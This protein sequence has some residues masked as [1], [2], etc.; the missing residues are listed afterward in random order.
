MYLQTNSRLEK[1]NRHKSY[2]KGTL[3]LAPWISDTGDQ[4]HVAVILETIDNSKTIM[5]QEIIHARPTISYNKLSE[6]KNHGLLEI[7]SFINYDN[8]GY[9]K[10]VCYPENWLLLDRLHYS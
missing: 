8:S 5:K 6:S 1:I 9:F 3:L 4:G 7:E 2:P 10:Y